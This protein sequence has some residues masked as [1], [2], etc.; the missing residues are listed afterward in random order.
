MRIT[1]DEIIFRIYKVPGGFV[2]K[3]SVWL[4]NTSDLIIGDDLIFTHFTDA[5]TLSWLLGSTEHYGNIFD[6]I[7]LTK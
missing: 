5:Q 7:D 6:N 1:D 2:I 4:E 3:S